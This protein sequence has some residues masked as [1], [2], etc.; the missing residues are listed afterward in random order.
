M[1]AIGMKVRQGQAKWQK[2]IAEQND[3][4]LSV[5]AYCRQHGV[6]EKTF[7]NWRKR[8]GVL[9]EPKQERFI[10]I[11]TMENNMAAQVLRLQIPGGYQLDVGPGVKKSQVQS[12]LEALAGLR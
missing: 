9:V 11:K 3:S 4:E 8:I 7:Y 12:V 6:N 5:S 10:Q 2:I 1:K